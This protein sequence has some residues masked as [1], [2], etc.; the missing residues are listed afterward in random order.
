MKFNVKNMLMAVVLG[1]TSPMLFAHDNATLDTMTTPNQGQLRMV[2]AYHL[3]L[4]LAKENKTAKES[5]VAIYLTDHAGNKVS[6]NGASATA[7]IL[8][9]KQKVVVSLLPADDNK[10]LGKASYAYNDK[11]KVAVNIQFADKSTGQALFTPATA[12]PKAEDQHQHHH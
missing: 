10:L 12:K 11:T 1:M 3:E 7:T 6:A 2:G 4:V 9:A 5:P 8:T